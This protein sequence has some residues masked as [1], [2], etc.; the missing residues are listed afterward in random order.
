[1]CYNGHNMWDMGWYKDRSYQVRLGSGNVNTDNDP[2]VI[3]LA[4]YGDYSKSNEA[5]PV[6]VRYQDIYM[7]FNRKVGMNA[8]TKEYADMLLVVQ[9]MPGDFHSHTDLIAALGV[10]DNTFLIDSS[11]FVQVCSFTPGNDYYPDYLTIV[12]GKQ[13]SGCPT[14]TGD[15]VTSM[16]DSM[17]GQGNLQI[18]RGVEVSKSETLALAEESLEC[19][20]IFPWVEL[21]NPLNSMDVD[22]VLCPKVGA[23]PELY[24]DQI[25]DASQQE[26]WKVCRLQCP[27]SGCMTSPLDKTP[28]DSLSTNPP[29]GA[30]TTTVVEHCYNLFSWVEIELTDEY[31]NKEYIRK[32]C[33]EMEIGFQQTR[34][35]YCNKYDTLTQLKVSEI[36]RVGCPNTGCS[37]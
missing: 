12:L 35:D 28:E 27:Q 15:I 37:R 14:S 22:Y 6:I 31:G 32:N 17:G 2:E 10:G 30:R 25:D 7:T 9:E 21:V 16:S 1:M 19:K 23:D 20:M 29:A 5:T 34:E 11:A 8:E 33:D 3:K 24:C 18:N 4:F 26:V 13:K 36:C